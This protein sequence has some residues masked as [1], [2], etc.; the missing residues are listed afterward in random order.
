[1]LPIVI[2]WC[3]GLPI[4]NLLSI[5]LSFLLRENVFSPSSAGL[6]RAHGSRPRCRRPGHGTGELRSLFTAARKPAP[7][8]IQTLLCVGFV[9]QQPVASCALELTR[10]RLVLHHRLARGRSHDFPRRRRAERFR[11]SSSSTLLALAAGALGVPGNAPSSRCHL[12]H[13][14][15][16]FVRLAIIKVY[17][18]RILTV[19]LLD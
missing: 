18:D 13:L 3:F 9:A 4:R 12:H 10:R 19:M 6:G 14:R 17:T 1:M 16:L 11:A 2:G 7:S 8:W 15:P 5:V